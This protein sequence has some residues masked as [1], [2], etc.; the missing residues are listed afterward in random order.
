MQGLE[1]TVSKIVSG[2]SQLSPG[3]ALS[4]E[5]V[6]RMMCA[7]MHVK[8]VLTCDPVHSVWSWSWSWNAVSPTSCL[9]V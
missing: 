6:R 7:H 1:N 9:T 5:Q 3:Q 2:A 8:S 4:V